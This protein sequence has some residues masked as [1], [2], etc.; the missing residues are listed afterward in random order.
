MAEPS[1]KPSLFWRLLRFIFH[2]L[3]LAWILGALFLFFSPEFV[4]HLT[5]ETAFLARLY[6]SV[7]VG[8]IQ[9]PQTIVFVASFIWAIAEPIFQD[10]ESDLGR[11]IIPSQDEITPDALPSISLPNISIYGYFVLRIALFFTAIQFTMFFLV[12]LFGGRVDQQTPIGFPSVTPARATLAFWIVILSFAY[13]LCQSSFEVGIFSG[14]LTL[15]I[16]VLLIRYPI[17]ATLPI[18]LAENILGLHPRMLAGLPSLVMEAIGPLP[19]FFRKKIATEDSES[20]ERSTGSNDR[21]DEQ[22]SNTDRDDRKKEENDRPPDDR[23]AAY[24]HA[25]KVLELEPDGFDADRLRKRYRDLMKKVHP[26]QQGSTVFTY[27]LR[28]AYERILAYHNWRQ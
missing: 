21:R 3:L 24:E 23:R 9:I 16:I 18:W 15:I 17:A 1:E 2:I 14:I 12:M 25:C 7:R 11:P 22:R 4:P 27:M 5:V 19:K 10:M 26:D 13:M 20:R 6:E 8:F 28:E